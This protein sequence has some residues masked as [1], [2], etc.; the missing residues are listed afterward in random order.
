MLLFI[1]CF[2][3]KARSLDNFKN[4]EAIGNYENHETL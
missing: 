1:P 2:T 3:F 4:E